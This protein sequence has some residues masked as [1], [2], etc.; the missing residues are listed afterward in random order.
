MEEIEQKIVAEL[1]SYITETTPQGRKA[2]RESELQK[3]ELKLPS[4][5]SPSPFQTAIDYSMEEVQQKIASELNTY[6]AEITPEGRKAKKEAKLQAE[7]QKLELLSSDEGRRLVENF[8]NYVLYDNIEDANRWAGE[9]IVTLL[10]QQQKINSPKPVYV[11]I[12]VGWNMKGKKREKRVTHLLSISFPNQP[13]VCLQLYQMKCYDDEKM[14][15]RNVRALLQL[16]FISAC[17]V[18]INRFLGRIKRYMH[19]IVSTRI[20]I[21]KLATFLEPFAMKEEIRSQLW[22]DLDF[23]E[24]PKTKRFPSMKILC[25]KYL[26][27]EIDATIGRRINYFRDPLPVNV[28]KFATLEAYHYRV[29]YERLLDFYVNDITKPQPSVKFQAGT[30][31]KVYLGSKKNHAAEGIIEYLGGVN[32]ESVQFGEKMINDGHA[33]VRIVEVLHWEKTPTYPD[34]TFMVYGL[35]RAAEMSLSKIFASELPIIAVD[36]NQ[37]VRMDETDKSLFV[38]KKVVKKLSK[39]RKKKAQKRREDRRMKKQESIDTEA[40]SSSY[41]LF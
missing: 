29:L 13:V 36:M 39:S 32:G 3:G 30:K 34:E 14:F 27:V 37:L 1:S 20:E 11:G 6:I 23:S 41:W 16:P 7:E 35:D 21:D 28:I 18:G 33:L 4:S 17:G 10:Q 12:H 40:N 8:D 5:Y 31:V 2:K 25:S 9:M 38:P 15:P 19:I 24:N 22:V 26:N